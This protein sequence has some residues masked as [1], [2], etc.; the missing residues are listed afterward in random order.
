MALPPKAVRRLLAPLQF[1]VVLG[2]LLLLLIALLVGLAP[3]LFGRPRLARVAAFL[4]LYCLMELSTLVLGTVLW[5][6][7][8]FRPGG[9]RDERWRLENETLLRKALE[10]VLG[11]ADRCLGF[12]IEVHPSSVLGGLAADPPVL[13]LARHGGPGDSFGLVHLL[14]TRYDRHPRIV[15]KDVLQLDPAIDLLLNR[16]GCCF[17]NRRRHATEAMR[18]LVQDAGYRDALLVFPEGGNWTPKRW[19][20]AVRRL[21]AERKLRAARAAT[22]MAH[23]LPPRPAGVLACL[24]EK[25]DLAVVMIAHAGLDRIVSVRDGWRQ[26]PFQRPMTVRLWPAVPP[27]STEEGRIQWLTM[28]WA[29]VDEWI[30]LHTAD[31]AR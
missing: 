21:W 8:A 24:E 25:P 18:R 27:P 15:L 12:R 23:V 20:R 13:V 1:A 29:I 16:L 17:I 4:L 30:D 19:W 9:H 10:T 7:H 26:L 28:E 11:A 3:A 22:L 5:V 31:Q 2:L 6:R 14:L